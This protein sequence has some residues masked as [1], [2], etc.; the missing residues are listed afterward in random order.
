[1]YVFAVFGEKNAQEEEAVFWVRKGRRSAASTRSWVISPFTFEGRRKQSTCE[2]YPGGVGGGVCDAVITVSQSELLKNGEEEASVQEA[3]SI[4]DASLLVG[5]LN[6]SGAASCW[7]STP[8]TP[9]I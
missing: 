7:N 5:V 2:E 1:M 3:T 9:A 4:A 8:P 6:T